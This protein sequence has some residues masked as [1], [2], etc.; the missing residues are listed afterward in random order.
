MLVLLRALLRGGPAQF[1]DSIKLLFQQKDVTQTVC[2]YHDLF[3]KVLNDKTVYLS[4]LVNQ[5]K[6]VK[7]VFNGQ[8][9]TSLII[10]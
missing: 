4:V 1:D 7:F 3:Q 2:F 9:T 10:L 6:S 5:L 8:F